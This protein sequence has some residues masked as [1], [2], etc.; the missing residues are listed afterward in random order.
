M[1]NIHWELRPAKPDP[2]YIPDAEEIAEME[3]IEK[4]M[5]ECD[6]KNFNEEDGCPDCGFYS[7]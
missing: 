7:K 5:K 4:L 6:H 3:E 2:Y 1:K